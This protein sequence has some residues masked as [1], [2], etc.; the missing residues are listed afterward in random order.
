MIFLKIKKPSIYLLS[1][2][3]SLMFLTA[4][5]KEQAKSE[6]QV[7]IITVAKKPVSTTLYFS[8]S[9]K[10]LE[11]SPVTTPVEGV[12]TKRYFQYGQ[13]V[14]TAKKTASQVGSLK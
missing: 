7:Q 14:I 3:F 1:L 12:I 4:C 5:S 6:K 9:I 8:G 2:L 11:A 10:P 13:I